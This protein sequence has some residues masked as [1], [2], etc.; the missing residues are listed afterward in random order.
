MIRPEDVEYDEA[1]RVWNGMIDKYPALI[2]RVSGLA[3]VI[4]AVNF[5]REHNLLLS[6]RGG[7]HNA[8]GHATNNGGLVIDLSLMKGI[9]VDPQARIAR[10]QG[11]VTWGELDR[12]TQV[13]GLATP[14][15]V[16]STTGIAGL[17]L[18]GGLGHLRRKYGMSIDNLRSA[19]VVTAAGQ[20]LTASPT[21]NPDLFSAIR[22]GGGNFGV[23]TSFEFNLH[24]VGP[25][26]V[27]LL[28]MYPA[29]EA[30]QVIPA[31]R[32]FMMTAP[33]ELTSNGMFTTVPAAPFMPV[34]IHGKRVFVLFGAYTGPIAEGE[35]L[36]QPLRQLTTPVIDFSGPAPYTAMQ[37]IFD[38]LFP[39]GE[40]LHY[41]KGTYLT[42]LDDKVIATI[43]E[44]AAASPSSRTIID[45]WAMGGAVS[46][47]AAQETAFGDRSAPF[48]LV[49]NT[50]W[51]DPKDTDKNIAWTRAFYE[52]MQPYSRGGGYLNFPGLSEDQGQEQY[53]RASFGAN[54]ER[55]A[56]V[57]NK[58]D[59]A[60]LFRLNQNIKPAA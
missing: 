17:T 12:E 51:S 13:F 8:A 23:V 22:G 32:D 3:D 18:G 7:G 6:V 60:N 21:E 35:R 57:K 50:T 45:L 54:Y 43:S 10:V 53:I 9:Q 30:G 16:V 48:W 15:G 29:E 37:S 58:Y 46:R 33:E 40:L 44:W 41:W 5:A 42:N 31:W 2:A 20:V 38:P 55:L 49:F 47:V 25:T 24:P 27:L 14:G 59:P 4:E 36:I 28:V 34:E 1:R 39:K 19:E 26:V 11:G 52:A 56:A